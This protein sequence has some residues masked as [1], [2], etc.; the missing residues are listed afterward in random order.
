LPAESLALLIERKHPHLADS[1]VTTVQAKN[2]RHVDALEKQFLEET[3]NRASETVKQASLGSIFRLRPLVSKGVASILLVASIAAF[4]LLAGESFDFWIERMQ[5]SS[6]PWPRKVMLSSPEFADEKTRNV[7]RSDSFEFQVHASIKAPHEAPSYVEIRYRR[8][9]GRIQRDRMVQVGRALPGRDK[10]QTFRYEFPEVADDMEFDVIGGDARLEDLKLRAVAR[11]AVDKLSLEC[12]Y[13]E[14]LGRSSQSIR[15]SSRQEIPVGTKLLC[16]VSA[17]KPLLSVRAFDVNEQQ[18]I[19]ATIS[20]ENAQEFAFDL[21]KLSEDQQIKLTLTDTDGVENREPYRL[22]LAAIADELPEV[23]VQLQGVSTA[24][25]PQA[26]IPLAG[27]ISD[28]YGLS[29]VWAEVALEE[30]TPQRRQIADL[31]EGARKLTSLE[32]LD[33]AASDPET[34]ERLLIAKPGEKLTVTVYAKDAYNLDDQ[35]RVAVC[36][37]FRLDVVSASELRGLLERREL[38]LRQRFESIYEK[39]MGTRDLLKRVEEDLAAEESTSSEE[40]VENG[41]STER[42]RERSRLRIIGARQNTT[43]LAYETLGVAEGFQGIVIEL[44]NNRIDTEDLKERLENGISQPLEEIASRQMPE[45]EVALESLRKAYKEES[46]RVKPQL[47]TAQARANEVVEA[48]KAVLDRM[49]EL[50]S[51]NELVVWLWAIV[52]EQDDLR[53]DTQE[54][55]KNKLRRLLED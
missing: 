21:A 36:P 13:P 1:L 53:K 30:Q 44:I 35:P 32:P 47:A 29:R 48:M 8:P 39:M 34:S 31:R 15:V 52:K 16:K 7:A 26:R 14:Y 55:R 12:T 5:L 10:F 17:T 51:Y 28:D 41:T 18:E 3:G 33:L 9:D 2:Q 42:T 23:S 46:S 40:D 24:V 49:L 4:A 45:L 50:E 43:Q 54:Q 27:V 20:S 37:R 11:P 38:G 22:D 19:P 25:T 6:T